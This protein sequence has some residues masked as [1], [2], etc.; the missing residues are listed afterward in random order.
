MSNLFGKKLQP[1]VENRYHLDNTIQTLQ[2][3]IVEIDE[4]F[5]SIF[6]RDMLFV[7][8]FPVK[9]YGDGNYIGG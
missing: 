9:A 3:V 6:A 2:S 7:Q 5:W 8:Y 4:L 1:I